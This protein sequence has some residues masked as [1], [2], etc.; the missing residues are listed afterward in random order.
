MTHVVSEIFKDGPVD[1]FGLRGDPVF[2]NYLEKHF[3]KV[4]MPY[5]ERKLEEDIRTIYQ[6]LTGKEFRMGE[7]TLVKDFIS[8]SGGMSSG[9][10]SDD[11]WLKSA[12]PLLKK[13]LAK[14]NETL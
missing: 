7:M 11:F 6:D 9:W 1:R 10:L 4:A 12:I 2:W 8:K 14:W 13:R 5:S 3:Q